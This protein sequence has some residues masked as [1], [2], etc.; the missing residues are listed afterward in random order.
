MMVLIAIATKLVGCGVGAKVSGIDWKKSTVV[1][2]G[3]VP[4]G[5]IA[6]IIGLFGLTALD[7]AGNKILSETEYSIIASM[8]FLTTVIVPVALQKLVLWAD[9]NAQKNIVE[10]DAQAA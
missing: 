2:F 9:R 7:A 6:L 5:E 3:M 1:G 10:Q 8:A 4:R